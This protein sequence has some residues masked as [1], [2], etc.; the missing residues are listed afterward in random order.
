M[1]SDVEVEDLAPAVLD[2]EEAIRGLEGQTGQGKEVRTRRSFLDDW[3][4]TTTSVW[5][6][7][8]MCPHPS[9][10]SGN[11]GSETS[12]PSFPSSHEYSARPSRSSRSSQYG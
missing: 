1:T 8:A 9:K 3:P 7:P 10:I 5:L 4:G 6:D 2:H 11:R 12:K